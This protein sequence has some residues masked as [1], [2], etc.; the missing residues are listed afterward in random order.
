MMQ[1]DIFCT[2]D[3]HMKESLVLALWVHEGHTKH[4]G[5]KLWPVGQIFA[6]KAIFNAYYNLPASIVRHEYS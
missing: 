1:L 4:T 6:C 3:H 5:V 2:A